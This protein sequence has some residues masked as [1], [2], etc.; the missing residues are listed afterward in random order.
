[1]LLDKG[2]FMKNEQKSHR[3]WISGVARQTSQRS[4]ATKQARKALVVVFCRM[5]ISM[6]E[7]FAVSAEAAES[8]TCL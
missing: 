3:A 1:M 5:S 4:N 7:C 6:S 2:D 8:A